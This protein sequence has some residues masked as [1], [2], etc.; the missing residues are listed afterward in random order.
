[1]TWTWWITLATRSSRRPNG[2][3]N[4]G[5]SSVPAIHFF[6]LAPLWKLISQRAR[7]LLARLRQ[8]A[9]TG[10]NRCLPCTVLNIAIAGTL[11]V[12]AA[13]LATPLAGAV[14]LVASLSAIYL[15]GYLVP[16]TPELTK[17]HAPDRLLRLFGKAPELPEPGETVDVEEYL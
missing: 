5:W 14:V 17:R 6:S 10:E 13:L 12:G 1:M 9:Y 3:S 4:A 7:R 2:C 8:P 16:G 11:A 15:R